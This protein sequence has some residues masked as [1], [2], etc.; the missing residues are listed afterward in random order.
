MALTI[1][2]GKQYLFV[3]LVVLWNDFALQLAGGFLCSVVKKMKK[4]VKQRRKFNEDE[5]KHCKLGKQNSNA[6]ELT[7]K[8]S[9]LPKEWEEAD[10]YGQR[11]KRMKAN[12]HS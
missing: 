3:N 5:G 2:Q 7:N 6:W 10:V 4:A 9:R 1:Y 12:Q 8:R 11:Q